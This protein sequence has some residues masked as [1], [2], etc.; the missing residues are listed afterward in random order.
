MEVGLVFR[1][2][3]LEEVAFFTCNDGIAD[4]KENWQKR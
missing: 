4:D 3:T 2:E 1:A